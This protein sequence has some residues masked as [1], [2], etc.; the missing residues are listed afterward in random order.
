MKQ[1]AYFIVILVFLLAACNSRI[2]YDK[3]LVQADSLMMLHPDS[4]LVLLETYPIKN[5][6][7]QA[8]SAYYALLLTQARDKNYI[9]QTNDSL[10]R[11][12]I[13]FYNKSD[14]I[15]MQARAYFYLGSVYRDARKKENAITQFFTAESLAKKVNDNHLLGLVYI[16]IA[17]LY[18]SK[19]LNEKADSI[20][21]MAEE[22][23]IQQK[24]AKLQAEAIRKRGKILM[25]KGENFYP[26]AEKRMLQSL[27]ITERLSNKR[28]K[29]DIL[30]SLSLL[31]N[32][33]NDEKKALEFAKQNLA[34]QEDSLKCY[35][36][37]RLLGSAYYKNLQYDSALFY[38]HKALPTKDYSTKA[39]TYMRLADIAKAQGNSALSLE[40]ERNYSDYMDSLRISRQS[41]A[42]VAAEKDVQI[43]RQQEKYNTSISEYRYYFLLFAVIVV[44]AVLFILKK[45]HNKTTRLQEEKKKLATEQSAMQQQHAQLRKELQQK[46][47]RISS[48]QNEIELLNY[49]EMQ[50]Q[51]LCIELNELNRER[52]ILLKEAF[53]SSNI[54]AKIERI[55]SSYK[56]YAKS[57]E[58]MEKEDW[59]QLIAETDLCWNNITLQLQS[60]YNLSQ[61]E[62]Y[63]CCLYLSDFSVSHFGYL[64]N[65]TR[66]AIYK[67]ANRILEQKMGFHHKDVSLK[68]VLVTLHLPI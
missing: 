10:I 28:F 58:Y 26:D 46:E 27:E 47:E 37:Y 61:E 2:N 6:R 13:A 32:W 59:L 42:I 57:E 50:K 12:A 38:L 15:K 39:G 55:I 30:S 60:K 4:A 1:N 36:S 54:H 49:N 63:L 35:D 41:S 14:D 48:L 9:T 45:T 53:D 43:H 23:A 62:I 17:N 7:T 24:N 34:I 8:D 40:M 67:K 52:S 20:Y 51:T 3:T 16:N 18:Y 19:D 31:Y 68:D 33:M 65:C 22:I 11:S 44:A 5:L 56:K 64:L 29:G 21:Q 66:D 25:E